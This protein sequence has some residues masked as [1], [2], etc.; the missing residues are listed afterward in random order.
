MNPRYPHP[1]SA[2]AR[3][4]RAL[5][6]A[7]PMDVSV[8]AQNDFRENFRRQGYI[9]ETGTLQ[10]WKR[11]KLEKKRRQNGRGILIQTGRLMRGIR[12]MPKPMMAMV[13]NSVPYAQAHNEGVDQKVQVKSHTRRRFRRSMEGTGIFNVNTRRERR[14][15]V[16]TETGSGTVKAHSRQMN[17]P[18]RP[19]M[20]DSPVLDK[21]IN[22]HIERELDRIWNSI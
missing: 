6:M 7:L 17:L 9:D 5:L 14:Q 18:A 2:A 10:K 1:F 21:E 11:R 15:T 16:T 22:R 20:R 13:V 4:F 19:F 3:Q 12:P 8:L